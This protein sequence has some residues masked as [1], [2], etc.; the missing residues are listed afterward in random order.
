MIIF[1]ILVIYLFQ[2]TISSKISFD[3][4]RSKSFNNLTPLNVHLQT[5]DTTERI[6]PID[7]IL[8]V[9]DS[10]SMYGQKLSL[11]KETIPQMINLMGDEDRL[12]I[13]K[14][15]SN[16]SMLLTL[17][18][19]DKNGKEEALGTIGKLVASGGTNIY[20]ALEEGFNIIKNIDYSSISRFPTIILL[21]DGEDNYS[22][23]VNNFKGLISRY[24][25]LIKKVPFTLHTFGY[26]NGHDA[27]LMYELSKI[28][29]GGYF[30]I[31]Q[32]ANIKNALIEIFGGS[33]TMMSSYYKISVQSFGFSIENLFGKDEMNIITSLKTNYQIEIIQLRA[34]KSYDF[35]FE[36]N[37]PQNTPKGTQILKVTFL[38]EEKI[39][40]YNDE[41]ENNA[42]E[43][44][45]RCIVYNNLTNSFYL[46]NKNNING[47]K[48]L[49]S[50][51][52]NWLQLNYEG[53][54]N[55]EKEIK[56][57]ILI[58]NNFRGEG[59]GDILSRIR[60]GVSQKPGAHYNEENSYQNLLIE[61]AYSIDVSE[62]MFVN[63]KP[64]DETKIDCSFTRNGSS[65]YLYSYYRKGVIEGNNNFKAYINNEHD[66]IIYSSNN[67]NCQLIV[68]STKNY[69]FSFYFWSEGNANHN[70]INV[71]E[72]GTK[73]LM[74][75]ERDFP[76][77][78]Y[79][80]I[81]GTK[82]INF[83]IEFL[84]L[85]K[86]KVE[87]GQNISDYF[88]IEA[89]I[90]DQTQIENIKKNLKPH[91]TVFNG[92]YDPG[93]RL[94]KV[95][96]S[97]SDIKK[98]MNSLYKNFIY[99]KIS[100]DINNENQYIKI[101]ALHSFTN[102][103][104]IYKVT[105]SDTYII[106][107]LFPGQKT[108]NLY[109]FKNKLQS[110]KL[111]LEFS[112]S[113]NEI[114]FALLGYSQFQLNE[115]RFYENDTNLEITTIK[116]MGKDYIDIQIK[117]SSINSIIL[118]IF[119]TNGDHIAGSEPSKISYTF[120]YY[121]IT[122]N[123]FNIINTYDL[124]FGE[125]IT[126]NSTVINETLKNLTIKF[127]QT[128]YNEK[129]KK[130]I[131]ESKYFLKFY[132]IVKK[133]QKLYNTI[134]L[135][136]YYPYLI[137]ELQNK[138]TEDNCLEVSIP[139]FPNNQS[140]FLIISSLSNKLNTYK[141][142]GIYRDFNLLTPINIT[143][144]NSFG[145]ELFPQNENIN[146][147]LNII[148]GTNNYLVIQ[149]TDY[150]DNAFVPIFVNIKGKNLKSVQ[151]S[152]NY[153]I[154]PKKLYENENEI[155]IHLK[156]QK[157]KKFYLYVELTDAFNLNVN[158][159]L[160]FEYLEEYDGSIS[161]NL[162]NKDG[163]INPINVFVKPL[164]SISNDLSVNSYNV[165]FEK[166][167]LLNGYTANI[168]PE[169]IINL[170]I[171]SKK[172]EIISLYTRI[173]NYSEKR[174]IEFYNINSYGYLQQKDCFFFEKLS[175]RYQIRIIGDKKISL[176]YFYT[177]NT[178]LDNETINILN[179]NEYYYKELDE[180]IT[181]IC[182][183][184][185]NDLD[186]IFFNLQVVKIDNQVESTLINEPLLFNII[187]KD[188]IKK[189]EIRY[190]TQGIFEKNIID[191]NTKY[192]F[193]LNRLKGE[194]LVFYDQCLD[195]PN[196]VYSKEIL[197][198][199]E[200]ESQKDSI[201]KKLFNID[202]VF[203]HSQKINENLSSDSQKPFVYIVEC[204][205]DICSYEFSLHKSD[206]VKN[207]NQLKKYSNSIK[208]T[209]IDKYS[210]KID[211]NN[212]DSISKSIITLYT[213]AGEVM[214][215]TNNNCDLMKH[216]IIGH[217]EKLEIAKECDLTILREI[218]IKA[219]MDSIYSIEYFEEN[220]ESIILN[221]NIIH[222]EIFNKKKNIIYEKKYDKYLIAKFIPV[223]C[224]IEVNYYQINSNLIVKEGNLYYHFI[225]NS[226]I[227]SYHQYEIKTNSENECLFY[228]YSE[229]ISENSYNILS[230]QVPYY[231]TLYN[232]NK[233]KLIYPLPN[234]LYDSPLFRI[235]F[236]EEIPLKINKY[237]GKSNEGEI[238]ISTVK[239]LNT[240][241]DLIENN[242]NNNEI[243]YLILEIT[244]E[245][246]EDKL[247]NIE[248][249]PKSS[250]Q[251]PSLLIQNQLK[252]DFIQ[253]NSIQFYMLKINKDAEGEIHFNYKRINGQ[254]SANIIK[255]EKKSWKN[256][257]D[258]PGKDEN[259]FFDNFK[260][261]VTLNKKETNKCDNGCYLF[262]GIYPEESYENNTKLNNIFMDYNIYYLEKDY[263]DNIVDIKLNENIQN[264][265]EKV[266][267]MEFYSLE[268]PYSTNTIYF[269]ISGSKDV[270]FTINIDKKPKLNEENDYYKKLDGKDDILIINN[271]TIKNLDKDLKG[272]R[273]IIGIYA[274][275]L[276]DGIAQFNF[277][278]RAINKYLNEYI[279]AD[280]NTETICKISNDNGNCIF[281][282][283]VLNNRAFF[284]N[285]Q[286]L[287]LYALSTSSS[288][289]LVL[290]F[291]KVNLNKKEEIKFE[292]STEKDF[293][294][295]M[296]YIPNNILQTLKNG[297]D[298]L[299]KVDVPEKGTITLFNTF[300]TNLKESYIHFKSKTIYNIESNKE[301]LL[302]IP[303][304]HRNLVHINTIDGEGII[305]FENDD[306]N[307]QS[308]SGKYS[309][310]YLQCEEDNKNLK[311]K[312]KTNENNSFKF[313]IYIKIGTNK[314]NINQISIGSSAKFK[315]NKGFPIEFYSQIPN[316]IDKDYIINFR[317]SNIKEFSNN[318]NEGIKTSIFKIKVFIIDEQTIEKI[319]SDESIIYSGNENNSFE[320]KYESGFGITKII[321]KKQNINSNI[322]NYLYI[323]ID[324]DST[325]IKKFNNINAELNILEINNIDYI[326]PD[327]IYLNGNLDYS[328]NK[329]E[330]KLT[331]KNKN[332]KKIRVELSSSEDVKFLIS[333]PK[334]SKIY[335]LL[336]E[337]INYEETKGLGKRYIDIDVET[338]NNPFIFSIYQD[339]LIEKK[340]VYYSFKYKTDKGNDKFKN[341]TTFDD[342][343]GI[344]EN[345]ITLEENKINIHLKFPSIK[346]KETSKIVKAKYYVKIYKYNESEIIVNN[347]I[348]VI[349]TISPI[350]SY[351]YYFEDLKD[352][353]EKDL[354]LSN[355]N[356]SYNYYVTLNA[357]IIDDN[358]F[359]GYKSFIINS[360]RDEKNSNKTN[361]LKWW[362]YLVI[363]LL[364]ILIIT[365]IILI[366]LHLKKNKKDLK[367]DESINELSPIQKN[368]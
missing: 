355:T 269:D 243:C 71:Y 210:I 281:L 338:I 234:K 200:K 306:E 74:E 163:N 9:D 122:E 56:E 97:M 25:E 80:L 213:H 153:L 106:S 298:I 109:L 249:I 241:K 363:I 90:V 324:A 13:F 60:E 169:N 17:T 255:I 253:L 30:S 215:S 138:K 107:N 46:A 274:T 328:N 171:K 168:Q 356:N 341:Y 296:L 29:D 34:G 3:I 64:N 307:M 209:E 301:L 320:G 192:I 360:K 313:Y 233:Y 5:P 346:D 14:F 357:I 304:G 197:E 273:L 361:I 223:N 16:P 95:T 123:E 263:K 134:N 31:F 302:N 166:N 104:N 119:S 195:Y 125:N 229:E 175:M 205:S 73:S 59:K 149:T 176:K 69:N 318:K 79:S 185:Y 94:G 270:I 62:K 93:F 23:S 228:T 92:F 85:Q 242:C 196:C 364:S 266:N 137:I 256:R 55:W 170:E 150:E 131:N 352:Y 245:S 38:D 292:Y 121:I 136:E 258:L 283:P 224:E 305:S 293:I 130:I 152:N 133:S 203:I 335:R 261:S 220:S 315:T 279:Y 284:E 167:D 248:I 10:G 237:I 115:Y 325:N 108:P 114:D 82:D 368:E 194:I 312:V 353:Y 330:Y 12:S 24:K 75:V 218:Y 124:K 128:I 251:I 362:N 126:F 219:N 181:K 33:V 120:N 188:K 300:K 184:Q 147:T 49:L 102:L 322:M 112:K 2:I 187:Y 247:I 26:G 100:K 160:I 334:I 198:Q 1:F 289:N 329:N 178:K 367:N 140:Y 189:N 336:Y 159:N 48:Q 257:Y 183:K 207:L 84:D 54:N 290:S 141:P 81:D 51:T 244:Y 344:F 63:V 182:L 246:K 217:I 226:P 99:I 42:F 294:K 264:T 4:S 98:Q 53:L 354:A 36:I 201:F 70:F 132:P 339:N 252:Q 310:M 208:Q 230:E 277:R 52:L 348:S 359:I 351:E 155:I 327:N 127:P 280:T 11:I 288:E 291:S 72:F 316:Q 227:G 15:N 21:S 103:N 309:S 191:D 101:R 156:N 297:E 39:Y 41:F 186:S 32:L 321:I 259:L 240:E 239:N 278:G 345:N 43:Q 19:M 238:E 236:I 231:L 265:I 174:N 151:P 286:H 78:F 276:I 333:Y 314:R 66:S 68:K 250:K 206:T 303:S 157:T 225:K 142:I 173:I 311:I 83:N 105:P 110:E 340:K 271:T 165:I 214:L 267:N 129:D 179:E 202:E 342:K 162:I 146:L 268:I 61:K 47:A 199:K 326:A 222:L 172:G 299:I 164:N 282:I 40:Y 358:E 275:S 337:V 148:N 18:S 211:K 88:I 347:T 193:S 116:G 22:N 158:D 65:L 365:M 180:Q 323:I 221:S 117:N 319:K 113:S 235:N 27:L 8:L 212:K 366:I 145:Y 6:N 50:N 331:K 343:E 139:N 91:S 262:I 35:V 154:I 287:F 190:Y 350:V 28:R 161:I 254:I 86:T 144:N 204:L 295:N 308:I 20:K 111:I 272:K 44:Y 57:C 89:Y 177:N 349:D 118:S 260:Q 45:I 58:Y 77:E 67:S 87:Y 135:F 285:N 317:I 216:T 7:L 76:L 232:T 332:D 96:I 37:I 143:D